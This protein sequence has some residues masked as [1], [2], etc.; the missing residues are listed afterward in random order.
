MPPTAGTTSG[1]TCFNCGRSGHFTRECPAP[2]RNAA[3]GHITHPPHGS[4]KMV[5]AKTGRVNYTTMEDI[6]E[7][8]PVLVGMF[9]L[10][11]H[12]V[13]VLFDSSATHDFVS[14]AC[15]QKCKLVI[16]PISAPYMITTLGERIVTMQVVINPPLNLKGRIYNTCLIILDG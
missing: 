6:F 11:D 7:G 10:N 8:E 15:T 12:S 13:V 3:Q 4:Q 5:V 1:N 9:F 14:K 2:K 16:E